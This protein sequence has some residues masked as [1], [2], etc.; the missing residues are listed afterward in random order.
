MLHQG[1]V[2]SLALFDDRVSWVRKLMHQKVN[3]FPIALLHE[4][5]PCVDFRVQQCRTTLFLSSW[6]LV[7]LSL[8]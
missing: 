5:L 1:N 4:L 6:Q 8:R 7:L 2:L 3:S